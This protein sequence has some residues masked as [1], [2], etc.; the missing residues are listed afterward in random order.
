MLSK[1]ALYPTWSRSARDCG[2]SAD[3]TN[4]RSEFAP[5]AER[6]QLVSG[7]S[8]RV[9]G[10]NLLGKQ[11]VFPAGDVLHGSKGTRQGCPEFAWN[12]A[13]KEKIEHFLR[14]RIVRRARQL[15]DAAR[16]VVVV[17]LQL[18]RF[19]LNLP[20]RRRPFRVG[21]Q[22]D[23]CGPQ[24]DDVYRRIVVDELSRNEFVR[25]K[26][27]IGSPLRR[28]RSKHRHHVVAR[29]INLG[30]TAGHPV[31]ATIVRQTDQERQ[32]I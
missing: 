17:E 16:G 1:A 30:Q 5:V 20:R 3:R 6:A 26:Q 13:A 32:E 12:Q 19:R 21:P 31:A 7:G 27:D 23:R 15:L 25:C 22:L 18:R 29:S 2:A 24:P 28:G 14:T 11:E 10:Q 9:W 4:S 8:A